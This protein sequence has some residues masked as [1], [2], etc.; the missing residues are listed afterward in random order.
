MDHT[1]LRIMRNDDRAENDPPEMLLYWNGEPMGPVDAFLRDLPPDPAERYGTY[2]S[3]Y[4]PRFI[5]GMLIGLTGMVKGLGAKARLSLLHRASRLQ[6]LHG[7][8][9]QYRCG[10]V[11]FQ[12]D[13]GPELMLSDDREKWLGSLG[14]A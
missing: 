6:H 13:D 14:Q 11:V 5:V 4:D 9:V 3:Y 2:A 7:R 12:P 8:F 10:I 1:P